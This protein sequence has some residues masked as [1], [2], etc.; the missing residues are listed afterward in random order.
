[1]EYLDSRKKRRVPSIVREIESDECH[2]AMF[3]ESPYVR[4]RD[5]IVYL[6]SEEGRELYFLHK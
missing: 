2:L 3:W 6:Q 1:M 4:L 5:K